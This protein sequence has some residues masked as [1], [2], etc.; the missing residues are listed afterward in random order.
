M[1][2]TSCIKY[3]VKDSLLIFTTNVIPR[4]L[5]WSITLQL[6]K[7]LVDEYRLGTVKMSFLSTVG[8]Y[9]FR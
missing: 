2:T 6:Q 8:V 9:A 1:S 4:Y 5:K 3:R 7:S